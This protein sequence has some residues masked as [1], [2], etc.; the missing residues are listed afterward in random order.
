[1]NIEDNG[2]VLWYLQPLLH[3]LPDFH[4]RKNS[5][6]SHTHVYN[7]YIIYISHNSLSIGAVGHPHSQL[8]SFAAH[9]HHSPIHLNRNIMLNNFQS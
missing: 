6:R 1:M 9:V 5:L 3:H 4:L 2:L 7:V 8:V